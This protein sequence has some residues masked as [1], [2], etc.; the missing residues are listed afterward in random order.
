[1][2]QEVAAA[3]GFVKSLL[4]TSMEG[5]GRLPTPVGIR[6]RREECLVLQADTRGEQPCVLSSVGFTM[7]SLVAAVFLMVMRVGDGAQP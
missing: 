4:T 5:A 3:H 6:D 2:L 1:M 7:H